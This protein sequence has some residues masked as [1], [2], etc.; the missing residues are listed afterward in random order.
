MQQKLQSLT[1]A[2]DKTRLRVKEGYNTSK[3][4]LRVVEGDENGTR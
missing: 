1:W 3:V 4:A 2:I